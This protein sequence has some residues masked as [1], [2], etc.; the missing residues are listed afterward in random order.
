MKKFVFSL[1]VL[2]EV[3]KAQKERLQTELAAA[4]AIYRA[5]VERKAELEKTLEERKEE[6]EARASAGMHGTRA[7]EGHA[8]IRGDQNA[9]G[10][11]EESRK[12]L[13]EANQR[14]NELVSVFKKSGLD[15]LDDSSTP[16]T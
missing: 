10:G 12:A 6:F 7:S 3:K 16:N 15:K 8:V 9:Q 13:R 5:A 1:N 4:E 11:P 14:R 2:Y